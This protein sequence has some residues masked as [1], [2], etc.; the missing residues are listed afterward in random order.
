MV[1]CRSPVAA[2]SSEMLWSRS[3]TTQAWVE[4]AAIEIG[5]APTAMVRRVA[6]SRAMRVDLVVVWMGDPDGVASG[7][8]RLGL[9][10]ERDAAERGAGAGVEGE[11]V[12]GA[13]G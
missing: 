4:F 7:G 12:V 2:S 6:L 13:L 5:S 9:V 3:L 1:R 8:E 10:A 11:D